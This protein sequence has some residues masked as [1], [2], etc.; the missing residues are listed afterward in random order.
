MLCSQGSREGD[1]WA[2]GSAARGCASRDAR[3]RGI[4]SRH[5]RPRRRSSRRDAEPAHPSSCLPPL[6][7]QTTQPHA[8]RGEPLR[9]TSLASSK[10][11]KTLLEL[12]VGCVGK[13]WHASPPLAT[14]K[15]NRV[16]TRDDAVSGSF[17]HPAPLQI[18]AR[19]SELRVLSRMNQEEVD[20]EVR[21]LFPLVF[22][23]PFSF[24]GGWLVHLWR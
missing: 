2:E 3:K 16:P 9:R 19:Y 6:S 14:Q 17:D 12:V 5:A 22:S 11:L 8:R 23:L 7:L 4:T 18:S 10:Q 21:G 20:K 13:R 24:F 1:K 15:E